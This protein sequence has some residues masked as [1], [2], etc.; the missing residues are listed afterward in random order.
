MRTVD[1]EAARPVGANGSPNHLWKTRIARRRPAQ[2]WRDYRMALPLVVTDPSFTDRA[3]DFAYR[4][5]C[6][7]RSGTIRTRGR[8]AGLLDGG[9]EE[10]VQMPY[11]ES[12]GCRLSLSSA[13]CHSLNVPSGRLAEPELGT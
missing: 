10:K 9:G 4:V 13:A 5:V 8:T 2:R 7:G 12:T 6:L 11:L 1:E 3:C